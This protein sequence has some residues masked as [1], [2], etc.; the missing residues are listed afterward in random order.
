MNIYF[1]FLIN[2]IFPIDKEI[3]INLIFFAFLKDFTIFILNFKLFKNNIEA[4]IFKLSFYV[5]YASSEKIVFIEFLS[6]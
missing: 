3:F 1:K 6:V 2:L 5:V 4:E